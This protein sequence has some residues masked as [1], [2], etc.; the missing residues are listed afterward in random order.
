[1]DG[2][3]SSA[4]L[5][6]QARW[7]WIR[8]RASRESGA[9]LHYELDRASAGEL[10]ETGAVRSTPRRGRPLRAGPGPCSG[11]TRLQWASSGTTSAAD[12][13]Q[14]GVGPASEHDGKVLRA[15]A[16]DGPAATS[17][18]IRRRCGTWRAF[19]ARFLRVV[20]RSSGF[21]GRSRHTPLVFIKAPSWIQHRAKAP[22]VPTRQSPIHRPGHHPCRSRSGEPRCK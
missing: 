16:V 13:G 20:V 14:G 3:S 22:P 11:P 1:V 8:V 18:N 6:A 17:P 19:A 21:G 12:T 10:S 4:G 5:V 2:I 15:S 7:P 9:V